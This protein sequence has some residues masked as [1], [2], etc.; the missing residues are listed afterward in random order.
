MVRF[1]DGSETAYDVLLS[2]MPV[3]QLV[4]ITD[5]LPLVGN[6]PGA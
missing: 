4:R 2:T 5:G 3:N 6:R 1:D